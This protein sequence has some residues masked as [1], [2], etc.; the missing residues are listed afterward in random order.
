[1]MAAKEIR[2]KMY[3]IV[4]SRWTLRNRYDGY[5][6]GETLTFDG[7]QLNVILINFEGLADCGEWDGRGLGAQVAEP[8]QPNLDQHV[9]RREVHRLEHTTI[10]CDPLAVLG[11]VSGFEKGEEL[12]PLLAAVGLNCLELEHIGDGKLLRVAPTTTNRAK[13]R[14]G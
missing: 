12:K 1:L 4:L 11:D 10:L 2:R 14:D 8:L 6:F 3:Q 5:D 13:V 9:L 7:P